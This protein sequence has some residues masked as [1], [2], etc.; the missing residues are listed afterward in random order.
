MAIRD[1]AQQ[2]ALWSQVMLEKY[3]R[4]GMPVCII[5]ECD[6]VILQNLLFKTHKKKRTRKKQS[7]VIRFLKKCLYFKPKTFIGT[8][9]LIPVISTVI[10]VLV[11][12]AIQTAR[13][14]HRHG[15]HPARYEQRAKQTP[16]VAPET[17][18]SFLK[19]MSSFYQVYQ[20]QLALP[21]TSDMKPLVSQTWVCPSCSNAVQ[22]V[23]PENQAIGLTCLT[24]Q[25]PV[26]GMIQQQEASR[27]ALVR[28]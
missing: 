18:D 2:K 15:A 13:A 27:A 1:E 28:E 9:V 16:T 3:K 24:C 26:S 19:S 23:A 11:T 17:V 5:H 22:V 7:P 4:R 8:N 25:K 10:G 14:P 21:T 12:N 6:G 20:N